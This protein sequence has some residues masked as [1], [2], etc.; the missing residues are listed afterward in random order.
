MPIDR[1]EEAFSIYKAATKNMD[2]AGIRQ[3]NKFYP[4]KDDIRRDL[5]RGEMYAIVDENGAALALVVLNA[6]FEPCYH[7]NTLWT[8][9]EEPIMAIH[10]L[11]VSPL[12][13]GCGLGKKLLLAAEDKLHQM[14]AKTIRL[15]AFCHNPV[16]L[17][18]YES[19]GY[20]RAGETQYP[21]GA[22]YF[23][24]KAL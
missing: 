9:H 5:E 23:Y 20:R 4:S 13:Q 24:E 6:E 22:F 18:L 1:L 12:V 10:R 14:G 8:L 3:W 7:E 15:D 11:C 19:N 17:H 16:A 2:A 21:A